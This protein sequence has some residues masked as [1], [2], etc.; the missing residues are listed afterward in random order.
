MRVDTANTQCHGTFKT[1]AWLTSYR[2]A[3]DNPLD[4]I[5]R[6]V[7]SAKGAGRPETHI[8]SQDQQNVGRPCWSFDTF[9]KSGVESFTVRPIFP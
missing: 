3:G 5:V 2:L 9:Q 7:A 8:I 4:G 1:S 6:G